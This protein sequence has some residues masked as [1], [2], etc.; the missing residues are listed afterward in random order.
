MNNRKPPT[1]LEII[2]GLLSGLTAIFISSII[3]TAVS[4]REFW[5]I[6]IVVSGSTLFTGT[7]LLVW[8]TRWAMRNDGRVS[9][10]GIGTLLMLTSLAAVYL[11]L[12][13]WMIDSSHPVHNAAYTEKFI[14]FCVY[15]V[16]LLAFS[17]IPLLS[18]AESLVWL[19]ARMVRWDPVHSVLFGRMRQKDDH[20]ND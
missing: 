1:I 17:L 15:G 7:I 12:A 13:R 11:S 9:Q 4:D 3:L 20:R 14:T 18:M 2:G 6:L 8:L 16:F 19:A 5:L 10:F